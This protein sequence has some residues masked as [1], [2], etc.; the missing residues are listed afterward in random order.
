ML[1]TFWNG[2]MLFHNKHP[3]GIL[4][5]IFY[6]LIISDIIENGPVSPIE[7]VFPCPSKHGRSFHSSNNFYQKVSS[8]H[9]IISHYTSAYPIISPWIPIRCPIISLHF[10]QPDATFMG[11]PTDPTWCHG[12][13]QTFQ[14]RRLQQFWSATFQLIKAYGAA[15]SLGRG[16]KMSRSCRGFTMKCVDMIFNIWHIY[17]YI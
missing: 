17:I 2:M 9:P 16:P 7:I 15:L 13:F 1:R 4:M 5:D 6:L 8:M 14:Q 12:V 3:Y 11:R 10:C